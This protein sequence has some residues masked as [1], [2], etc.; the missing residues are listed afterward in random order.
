MVVLPT[1]NG[2]FTNFYGRFTNFMVF[3]MVV[4]PILWCKGGFT[5]IYIGLGPQSS[6][7]F[8]VHEGL[9]IQ[10]F[11]VTYES[12]MMSSQFFCKYANVYVYVYVHI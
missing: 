5:M 8:W 9:G 7:F 3:L 2:G 1:F 6:F 4:L 11:S 10:T 12:S